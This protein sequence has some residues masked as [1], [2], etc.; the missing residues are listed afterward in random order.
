[1]RACI[2]RSRSVQAVCTAG[3]LPGVDGGGAERGFVSSCRVWDVRAWMQKEEITW[4]AHALHAPLVKN[5]ITKMMV[6]SSRSCAGVE[7]VRASCS[8]CWTCTCWGLWDR[9]ADGEGSKPELR[10]SRCLRHFMS[11]TC[12]A[13]HA[14]PSTTAMITPLA[15][16]STD[17]TSCAFAP[18]VAQINLSS[19][20]PTVAW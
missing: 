9:K 19:S 1:M 8:S 16:L 6:M 17:K 15:I 12:C 14:R 11:G 20:G 3:V 7:V 18:S 2:A 5:A 13:R 4:H 10:G